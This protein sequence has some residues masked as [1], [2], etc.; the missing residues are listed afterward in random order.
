MKIIIRSMVLFLL[1]TPFAHA[2]TAF[3]TLDDK[4]NFVVYSRA[5]FSCITGRQLYIGKLQLDLAGVDLRIRADEDA[6][7]SEDDRLLP[8]SNTAEGIILTCPL[9]SKKRLIEV[10]EKRGSWSAV[11]AL[12]SA[13]TIASVQAGIAV[14]H[15]GAICMLVG[16]SGFVLPEVAAGLVRFKITEF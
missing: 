6:S 11:G 4:D 13:G 8:G 10:M 14:N 1:S 2:F 15:R 5:E 12:A 3:C 16:G 7:Y 9:V